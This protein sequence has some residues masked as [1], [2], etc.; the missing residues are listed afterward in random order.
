MSLK[1][2]FEKSKKAFFLQ[3]TLILFHWGKYLHA[4]NFSQELALFQNSIV[5]AGCLILSLETFK[6]KSGFLRNLNNLILRYYG[7]SEEG[8]P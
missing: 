6:Q 3:F 7:N 1:S 8:L 5:A 2:S 4:T